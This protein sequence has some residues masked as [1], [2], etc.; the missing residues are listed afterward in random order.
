MSVNFSGSANTD[1]IVTDALNIASGT[2]N[3]I[4]NVLTDLNQNNDVLQGAGLNVLHTYEGAGLNSPNITDASG[5]MIIDDLM[6]K[7]STKV[8][9]AAQLLSTANTI[10]KTVSRT[11]S[12]G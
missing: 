12:Q 11:M 8:Q 9:V 10:N 1:N 2:T 5:A 3:D 7:I 6:Q 4:S